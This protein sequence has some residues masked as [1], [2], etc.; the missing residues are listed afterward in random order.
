MPYI[1]CQSCGN[2]YVQTLDIDICTKCIKLGNDKVKILA[3]KKYLEKHPEAKF[4][5]VSQALG[6]RR[7]I[8]DRFVKE[9]SLRLIENEEKLA[10]ANQNKDE[11]NEKDANRSKQRRNLIRQLADMDN[12]SKQRFS[13]EE[14]SKLLIDLEKRRKNGEER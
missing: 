5:E 14:R 9:G 6:I 10:I 13:K 11:E 2:G 3:I 4:K 1:K 12:Y 7:E 8:M